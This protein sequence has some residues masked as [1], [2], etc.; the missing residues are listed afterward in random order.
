MLQDK[1][2]ER[3]KGNEF[4]FVVTKR[5][6]TF[7]R[8]LRT[9]DANDLSAGRF[10]FPL[11]F[12]SFSLARFFSIV[13]LSFLA[14]F[15]LR[16]RALARY[17]LARETSSRAVIFSAIAAERSMILI[18][19]T[20]MHTRNKFGRDRRT[21]IYGNAPFLQIADDRSENARGWLHRLRATKFSLEIDNRH[22]SL[23]SFTFTLAILYYIYDTYN[24]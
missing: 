15:T 10:P 11:L 21:H 9:L 16:M 3:V 20:R 12:P 22:F 19:A 6:Y 17:T 7:A 8:Q 13:F 1:R 24:C 23:F 18:S 14:I 4:Y 2:E 5:D